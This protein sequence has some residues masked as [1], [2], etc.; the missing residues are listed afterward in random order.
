MKESIE[1]ARFGYFQL[2]LCQGVTLPTE[3]H[4]NKTKPNTQRTRD[5]VAMG[6]FDFFLLLWIEDKYRTERLM[7][8]DCG[9]DV[10]PLGE[11]GTRPCSA[12]TPGFPQQ[13]QGSDWLPACCAWSELGGLW[14]AATL[15]AVQTRFPPASFLAAHSRVPKP[16]TLC[17]SPYRNENDFG[18]LHC[19]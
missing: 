6:Y 11:P 9:P 10:P 16:L 18:I 3:N 13:D 1:E 15:S 2:I 14:R 4:M 17:L 5:M 7:S 12:F 19:S 8:G